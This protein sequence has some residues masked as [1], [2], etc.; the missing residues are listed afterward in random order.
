[1]LRRWRRC[2]STIDPPAAISSNPI[3]IVQRRSSPVNGRVLA[4]ALVDGLVAAAGLLLEDGDVSL[5]G[6]G[7]LVSPVAVEGEVP[8]EGVV[9]GVVPVDGVV[10]VVGVV[11]GLGTVWLYPLVGSVASAL[12][13]ASNATAINRATGTTRSLRHAMDD[14][15]LVGAGP[16]SRGVLAAAA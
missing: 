4:L 6:D 10:G 12:V 8:D 5:V 14:P 1:M 13:G 7:A 11:G 2:I 16:A 3:A 15:F 9:D